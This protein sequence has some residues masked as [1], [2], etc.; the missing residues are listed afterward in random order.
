MSIKLPRLFQEKLEGHDHEKGIVH[1]ALAS[2]G[3]WFETSGTTFFRD[4][5]DHGSKHITSV[6]ATGAA[7]IPKDA[8]IV[9]S[10][11]DV[12][13]FVLATLLHDSA[14]HLAEPGFHQLIIGDAKDRRIEAFDKSSWSNIWEEFL[15]T[16]R[17]WSNEKLADVFG[18]EFVRRGHSVSNPFDRW[19]N[20]TLTDYKLIGEFIRRNHPRLAHEF[21]IFGIPGTHAQFLT[22]PATLSKEWK[23]IAGVTARSHGLPLRTCLDNVSK[24]YQKR[25]Y[26]SIHIV[27]LMA[28]L[29]LS[30]Y[31]QIEASRAPEVVFGY[32]V[33]PSRISQIEWRAHHAVKNITPEHEDPESVEIRAAPPDVET[34]L[35]LREWIDGIQS[36]LDISWAVLG[37]VYGRYSKLRDLGLHWRRV[38]SNLD[39]IA[40]FAGTVSYLPRRIRVEVARAELLSLLIRPLYGDDPTYGVRELMQNAVDAVREREYYQQKHPEFLKATF[41]E[42]KADVVIWLSDYDPN[43][44][45]AWMEFSDRGIGMTEKVITDYFLTAGASYRHSEQWQRTYERSDLPPDPTQPRSQIIR[46]GRFGV[47]ALAAFLVG[48]EIEV[49]TRHITSTVGFR[50]KMFLTQEAVHIERVSD[51]P[52]GTTIRM[53]VSSETLVKL[54]KTYD[55]VSKPGRW[56]WYALDKP[57]VLRLRGNERKQMFQRSEIKLEDWRVA[58]TILP[59]TIHWKFPG[60][61]PASDPPALSCN[62]IFVSNASKL[63]EITWQHCD[64][65]TSDDFFLRTPLLHVTDPDGHLALGLTR[66]E[67]VSDEYGFESELYASI[68]KDFFARLLIEF[69][70][71]IAPEQLETIIESSP[72]KYNNPWGRQQSNIPDLLLSTEGFCVPFNRALT[73]RRPMK[74]LLWSDSI[75]FLKHVSDLALWDCIVIEGGLVFNKLRGDYSDSRYKLMSGLIKKG[76]S[77]FSISQ[78]RFTD[79]QG[80]K[81]KSDKTV[82]KVDFASLSNAVEHWVEWEPANTEKGK[83]EKMRKNRWLVESSSMPASKYPFALLKNIPEEENDDFEMPFVVELI[84]EKP[85]TETIEAGIINIWWKRLFGDEWIPW[86]KADRRIKFQKAFAELEPYIARYEKEH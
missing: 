79:E 5:T 67:V 18:D 68:M 32:R 29:R 83:K 84:L 30:D 53:R 76:N 41:K 9:L 42:Q 74:H 59:L 3:Q 75:D 86:K 11:A 34:F 80:I 69:P 57:T 55:T 77:M 10:A 85:W 82:K 8:A 31:L 52:V 46:S 37:E 33:L 4:Y 60:S 49:E 47:G 27:Y 19:E 81:K 28:L 72:F 78:F 6:L 20:L 39:D 40:A 24:N 12:T 17:R 54:E 36:E 64:C 44:K 14:L 71:K 25:D 66:K 35:R 50:F 26:Q 70:E 22:L 58:E 63:P 65:S 43:T 62:G 73:G 23:D 48:E 21:A 51:L 13:I 45:C 15:F 7:M 61:Y 56:D 16:A 38:R 2:F 1:S